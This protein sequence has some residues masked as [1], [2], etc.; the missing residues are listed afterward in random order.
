MDSSDEGV[1]FWVLL[2]SVK[3]SS[4]ANQKKKEKQEGTG[5]IKKI[6][7]QGVYHNVN[8]RIEFRVICI[9]N[10]SVKVMK[11]NVRPFKVWLGPLLFIKVLLKTSQL[12]SKHFPSG[13][14]PFVSFISFFIKAMI[15]LESLNQAFSILH[16][17]SPFS[18]VFINALITS[19]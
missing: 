11:K 19:T 7:E 9:I 6:T 4:G 16:V 1:L 13:L 17:F 15:L 2:F 3:L 8:D 12:L 18:F 10:F 5:N 14:S